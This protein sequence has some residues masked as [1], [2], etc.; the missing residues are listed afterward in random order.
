[1]TSTRNFTLEHLLENIKY[2]CENEGCQEMYLLKD[3][4]NHCDNCRHASFDCPEITTCKWSGDLTK[5]IIHLKETH[6]IILNKSQ[7]LCKYND[8]ISQTFYQLIGDYLF[9][10]QVTYGKS[11]EIEANCQMYGPCNQIDKYCT[12]FTA[13]GKLPNESIAINKSCEPYGS[14]KSFP[15]PLSLFKSIDAEEI[16][17][18]VIKL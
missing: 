17:F 18:K 2:S 5:L 9:V 12:N 4:K 3:V 10:T 6:K 11:N 7:H 14:T 1:M 16:C 15:M 8:K 13:N